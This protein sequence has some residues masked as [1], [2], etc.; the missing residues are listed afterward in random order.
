[1]RR[2]WFCLALAVL[3]AGAPRTSRPAPQSPAPSS[4]EAALDFA[5]AS[6]REP[7]CTEPVTDAGT[8][9]AL[10]PPW[11]IEGWIRAEG[12]GTVVEWAS[13][14]SLVIS[15][16]WRI[17]L[18]AGVSSS[19]FDLR[20]EPRT[21][22]HYALEGTER[23]MALTLWDAVSGERSTMLPMPAGVWTPGARLC[24]GGR[25]RGQGAPGL[26]DE[27]RV[28]RGTLTAEVRARWR[29]RRFG[30]AHPCHEALLAA[31]PFT[32][33]AGDTEMGS[34]L[35]GALHSRGAAW[36]DLPRL[37]YGPL[38]RSVD[39]RSARV[40][41]AA[42][43]GKGEDRGW[44]A[45]LLLQVEGAVDPEVN[46]VAFDVGAETDFVAHVAVDGLQ[47]QQLYRY[48]PLIDGRAAV[49][50]DEIPQ[51]RTATEL[52]GKNA[53]FTAVF[54]ADQHT[55]DRPDPDPLFAYEAAAAAEPL[56]WA[57]LGDV[58]P[59]SVDGRTLEHKRDRS[60]LRALWRRNFG[61]WDTPQARFLRRYA[62]GLATISDHEI[63]NNYNMNWHHHDYGAAASREASTLGDR[64][65]QY[66][67][68]MATWWNH[69]G[70][71]PSFSDELGREARR[72]RGEAAMGRPYGVAGHY[73]ALA[74]FP[75]VEFFALDTTSYRGD[76]Y[77]TR[78][79]SQDA[80]RD[81]D[82]SRYP[83]NTG[84]GRFFI[85][86]DRSHGATAAT[87]G[88][89]SWLGPTQKNAFL[90]ALAAST[91][92]VLVVAAGYPLYSVKFQ[93]SARYWEGRESGL[94]FAAELDE[95]MAALE[96]TDRLVLWV[97]GDGHSPALVRLRKNVYQ[98]Q[99]GPTLLA[100]G[101]TGHR[102]LRVPNGHSSSGDV[103]GGG[104]LLAGHQPD[105]TPDD[106]ADDVFRSGLD[107]FEGY[108]RLY[109]HP[110]QEALRSSAPLIRRR[111][112][113]AIEVPL[114]ADPAKNRA[115]HAAVGRV[116]R[117]RLAD[118][119]VHAVV[120]AYRFEQ[121]R[122]VFELDRSVVTSDP[123]DFQ[124]LIDA[125]PWVEARWFDAR[126]REWRDFAAVL[127]REP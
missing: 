93:D 85:F 75:F 68:S 66:D 92:R 78:I 63:T 52:G 28:F 106:P 119:V 99:V 55:T 58:V 61:R 24:L 10:R 74:P 22:S 101:G 127:R 34:G 46:V 19:S 25:Q 67:V 5:V 65:A 50:G 45:G 20:V 118:D 4:N 47:P 87:D 11:T 31:W 108:L 112:A 43:T 32:A 91:A 96:R 14:T 8:L 79:H 1:M 56:F 69:F 23:G 73:H 18:E 15:R 109:F 35:M 3:W 53:D 62:L 102:V 13:H 126:G 110:G 72:D 95:I 97:H 7:W 83:W 9:S 86:G 125:E 103:L 27:T 89:R 121:D 88:I 64:I 76:P 51:F 104:R 17:G 44:R 39:R 80:N 111:G 49:A 41:F 12:S 30:P 115:G 113:N 60:M 124:L 70:W 123:V 90:E 82:H 59:G 98:L 2:L 114:G 38:L 48:V 120:S 29:H 100:G 33:G 107:K 42:R 77:Q 117:L 21:W 16:D 116:A 57:Q 6:G 84:A 94:D 105:L 71:G 81:T 36:R 40:L 122:A 54:L 37:A 26:I